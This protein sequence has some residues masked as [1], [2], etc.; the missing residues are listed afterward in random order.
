[1]RF[2]EVLRGKGRASYTCESG[3]VTFSAAAG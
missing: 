3:A 2:V 1:M